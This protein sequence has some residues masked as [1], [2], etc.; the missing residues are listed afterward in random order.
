[1]EVSRADDSSSKNSCICAVEMA[2][3]R[4]G[5]RGI[6]RSRFSI[7]VRKPSSA[8][9][10]K[11][12]VF[13]FLAEFKMLQDHYEEVIQYNMDYNS[14][15]FCMSL[16]L[17]A[18]KYRYLCSCSILGFPSTSHFFQSCRIQLFCHKNRM[19]RAS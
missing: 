1:M 5:L 14:S 16:H 19:K 6:E 3:V 15:A 10:H 2:S 7:S 11:I 12:Q 9:V 18:E 4:K 17:H 8:K 13:S